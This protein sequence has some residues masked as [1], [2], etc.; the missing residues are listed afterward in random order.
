MRQ[1]AQSFRRRHPE[2]TCVMPGRGTRLWTG[3]RRPKRMNVCECSRQQ[4]GP[5]HLACVSLAHGF[6]SEPSKSVAYMLASKQT[7]IRK[8]GF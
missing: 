8:I 2:L 3:P 5:W 1:G 6:V 4:V 7:H